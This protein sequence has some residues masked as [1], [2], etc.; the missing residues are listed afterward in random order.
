LVA[1]STEVVWCRTIADLRDEWA[2][3]WH[4]ARGVPWNHPGWLEAW[5]TAFARDLRIVAV[6]R[7]G[8]LE[9]VLPMDLVGRELRAAANAESP[10]APFCVSDAQAATALAGA[11]VARRRWV[12]V[13]PLEEDSVAHGALTAATRAAGFAVSEQPV[14]ASPYVR[15]DAWDRYLSA[16]DAKL[17]RE[18]RRRWRRLADQAPPRIEFHDAAGADVAGLL[19]RCFDV[20]RLGWKGQSGTAIAS[21]PQALRFYRLLGRWAADAGWLRIAFLVSGDRTIAFD[22]SLECSGTHHLLKTSFD[23]SMARF[24]PG[25]LLRQAMVHRAFAIGLDRYD[26][27]GRDDGWK[28]QWADGTRPRVHLRA[29]PPTIDGR[30]GR[31]AV[32]AARR[33]RTDRLA[34]VRR[35]IEGARSG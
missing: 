17:G 24:A 21:R 32:A 5:A 18:I 8:R 19:Q 1:S 16:R 13:S 14:G 29:F 3:L 28:M 25:M 6:R 27:L 31:F 20:E 2:E 34:A 7:H 35:F 26:F 30:A 15:V 11:L 23:P 22:L 9:G 10:G 12:N 4:R 33:L